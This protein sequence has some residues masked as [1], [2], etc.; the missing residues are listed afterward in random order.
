MTILR[1]SNYVPF[2]SGNH[3][4][5]LY[6]GNLFRFSFVSLLWRLTLFFNVQNLYIFSVLCV[7]K[8]CMTDFVC[9]PSCW[10]KGMLL[11]VRKVHAWGCCW[12][13]EMHGWVLGFLEGAWIFIIFLV[14]FFYNFY[15]LGF[16]LIVLLQSSCHVSIIHIESWTL[17]LKTFLL[18][19]LIRD[20]FEDE[21]RAF[22]GGKDGL[23]PCVW[24]NEPSSFPLVMTVSLFL[25]DVRC[26]IIFLWYL[27]L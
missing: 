3:V 26:F 5:Y 10:I 22:Q 11:D 21:V 8:N 25:V 17:S 24:D 16:L 4:L 9:V 2:H 15:K 6:G 27:F 1:L 7:W 18:M 12:T 14:P 19:S 20:W 13:K 23:M